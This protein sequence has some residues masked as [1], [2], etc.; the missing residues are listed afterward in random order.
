M[1]AVKLGSFEVISLVLIRE[2]SNFFIYKYSD[3]C[4]FIVLYSL[5]TAYHLQEKKVYHYQNDKGNR[6]F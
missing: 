2:G 6:F 4:L 1:C 5:L 3:V